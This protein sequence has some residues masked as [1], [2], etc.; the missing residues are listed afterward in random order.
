MLLEDFVLTFVLREEGDQIFDPSL[1]KVGC[2]VFHGLIYEV[3]TED[4]SDN[5]D[6]DICTRSREVRR[7]LETNVRERDKGLVCDDR[8][9]V[10]DEMIFGET[11]QATGT[12]ETLG[13][14]ETG[15]DGEF[16]PLGLRPTVDVLQNTGEGGS[17]KRALEIFISRPNQRG[18]IEQEGE[19][20]KVKGEPPDELVENLDI[21][22]Y[23][24]HL[25]GLFCV[26]NREWRHGGTIVDI[27]A[28]WLKKTAD[29]EDL[30]ECICIFEIFEG[31][32]CLN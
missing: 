22:L 12:G 28:P 24:C 23:L 30:E 7:E 6:R 4:S 9:T 27:A 16:L 26:E 32:S 14:D 17:F 13:E 3:G 1:A 20:E 21:F 15:C 2:K 25:H 29:E 8:R 18:V 5:A 10:L 19:R 11:L 31:R